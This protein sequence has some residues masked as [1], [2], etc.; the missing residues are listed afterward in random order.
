[1]TAYDKPGQ[2]KTPDAV[3]EFEL[4]AEAKKTMSRMS[5]RF[6]L[7]ADDGSMARLNK[8]NLAMEWAFQSKTAALRHAARRKVAVWDKT[9]GRFIKD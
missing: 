5:S 6:F 1:M 9:L 7:I 4:T 2:L 3:R 8:Y